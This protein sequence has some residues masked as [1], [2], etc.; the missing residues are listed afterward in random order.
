[1]AASKRPLLSPG[2]GW[3][4][5]GR[6]ALHFRST[7]WSL[8]NQALGVAGSELQHGEP[9][10]AF[11]LRSPWQR[12]QQQWGVFRQEANSLDAGAPDYWPLFS[13]RMGKSREPQIKVNPFVLL[14]T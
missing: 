13:M 6:Q 5:E 3:L 8:H 14:S 10:F 9:F 12:S 11:W 2:E 4:S 7:H 1:M